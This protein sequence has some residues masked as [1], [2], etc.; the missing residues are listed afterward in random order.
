[1]VI[2]D[3][4][5]SFRA[6]FP[7]CSVVVFADL[8]TGMVLAHSTLEKTVQERLDDLCQAA[9]TCF[10]FPTSGGDLKAASKQTAHARHAVQF[11]AEQLVCF[12]QSPHC[13]SEALCVQCDP[14]TPVRALI[15][16]GA[17]LLAQIEQEAS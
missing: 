4:L 11:D 3:R 14:G 6:G 16:Q 13:S 5:D 10:N 2:K 8:S 12:I 15:G 17:D 9:M 1:M 7:G